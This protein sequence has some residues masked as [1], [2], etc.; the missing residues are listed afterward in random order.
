MLANSLAEKVPHEKIMPLNLSL[1][2]G[3][4]I[5]NMEG[6]Y[7]NATSPL[8]FPLQTTRIALMFARDLG[9]L[10]SFLRFSMH[11]ANPFIREASP[12][13][14]SSQRAKAAGTLKD[15]QQ[16]PRLASLLDFQLEKSFCSDLQGTLGSFKRGRSQDPRQDTSKAG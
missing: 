1:E 13:N 15:V 9:R 16:A 2:V 6:E 3:H 11:Q 14:L 7:A 8:F 10:L 4:I 5:Q 12:H